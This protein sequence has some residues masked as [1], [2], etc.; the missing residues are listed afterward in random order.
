MAFALWITGPPASGKSTIAQILVSELKMRGV[1]TQILESD[2]LR[3]VLTPSPTYTEEEREYF[4]QVLAYI[5]QLL[6][7][8][9]VNVIIDA[10]ANREA[11]RRRAKELIPQLMIVLLT[12]SLK[13]R[14]R[15]DVKGLYKTALEGKVTTL[16]GLQTP[17]EEPQHPDLLIN[18]DDVDPTEA[19]A[20]ILHLLES[21]TASS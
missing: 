5:A 14:R 21:R 6:T 9:H 20:R 17:Y 7:R 19:A 1:N 2:E 13:T 11:Y 3:K 16:P 18:T 12:C 10:T 15:R 8:N 4:Y